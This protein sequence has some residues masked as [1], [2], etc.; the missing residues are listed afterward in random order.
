VK[1][2]RKRTDQAHIALATPGVPTD[3]PGRPASDLLNV[4]LGEGMTSR[5]FLEVRERGGLA[6]DIHS[7]AMHYRDTGAMTVYCGTDPSKVDAA[8]RAVLGQFASLAGGVP[9]EEAARALSYAVGR[10]DLRLEDSRAVMGWVGGQE[11]LRERV[12]TPDE[13]VADLR[14]VTTTDLAA[15]A[16]RL[17]ANADKRLAI[18]GPFASEA[19]FR[20]LLAA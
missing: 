7:A 3:A 20:K 19:R 5:L 1:V 12:R 4:I 18:V 13:V 10:L 16:G 6:Y 9:E 2:Y 15:A 11:L 14:T 17:L 8:L